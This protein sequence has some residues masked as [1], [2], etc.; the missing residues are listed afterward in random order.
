MPLPYFSPNG[1]ADMVNGMCQPS[2]CT[3]RLSHNY[4]SLW[5]PEDVPRSGYES[6]GHGKGGSRME[7]AAIVVGLGLLIHIFPRNTPLLERR[8]EDQPG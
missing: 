6:R 1:V 2:S 5:G 8:Y 3:S 4:L 7:C